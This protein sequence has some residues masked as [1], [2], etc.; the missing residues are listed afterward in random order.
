LD[1]GFRELY[2]QLV[3]RAIATITN[4]PLINFF[5]PTT[6]KLLCQQHEKRSQ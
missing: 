2:W 3:K 4:D 6:F 1:L 5:P